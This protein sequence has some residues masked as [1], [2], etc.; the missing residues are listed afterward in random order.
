MIVKYIFKKLKLIII[1]FKPLKTLKINISMTDQ[2]QEYCGICSD[3]LT[4]KN[5]VNIKCGHQQCQDCFWKWAETSNA[6]PF[7]R[8]DM[9]PRDREKELE[10]ENMIE[11][12]L[13][14]LHE[15]DGLYTEE[16]KL[17]RMVK[18]RVQFVDLLTKRKKELTCQIYMKTN[19][20]D[21]IREWEVDPEKA[22]CNWKREQEHFKALTICRDE[23][24][25]NN[26]I[27]I[28]MKNCMDEFASL[29][30]HIQRGTSGIHNQCPILNFN[31]N[32]VPRPWVPLENVSFSSPIS[33]NPNC[34]Q[35]LT[36]R[37]MEDPWVNSN[38][39]NYSSNVFAHYN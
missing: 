38:I 26:A 2:A 8:A 27:R 34:V 21:R 3:E 17:K 22:M 14:I 18:T 19:I 28:K 30:Q 5:V 10:M 29:H 6:C 1:K 36:K 15:L 39:T 37:L 25:E 24:I 9:I 31:T 12:R 20:V 4:V 35:A 11:R 23:I 13:E 32:P 16:L 7:C 33:R